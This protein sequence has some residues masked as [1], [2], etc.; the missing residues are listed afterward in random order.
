MYLTLPSVVARKQDIPPGRF[1]SD[2]SNLAIS[3]SPPP[4]QPQLSGA[5]SLNTSDLDD[6]DGLSAFDQTLE[7]L[8]NGLK[9]VCSFNTLLGLDMM[10]SSDFSLGHCMDDLVPLDLAKAANNNMANDSRSCGKS[11][12]IQGGICK[13]AAGGGC[14][15]SGSKLKVLEDTLDDAMIQE[16]MESAPDR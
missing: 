16:L 7:Q 14:S 2:Y 10:E 8:G 12:K 3:A 4:M 1:S 13:R 5:L 9:T 11:L 15:S 6:E